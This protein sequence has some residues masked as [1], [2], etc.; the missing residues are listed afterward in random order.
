M[1]MT[2]EYDTKNRW[3][4]QKCD[5]LKIPEKQMN[6]REREKSFLDFRG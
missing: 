6:A 4:L 1:D 3:T 2:H 5:Q